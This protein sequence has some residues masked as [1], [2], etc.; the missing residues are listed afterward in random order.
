MIRANYE[1]MTRAN[2]KVVTTAGWD[3][4]TVAI[5]Y[6]FNCQT[7]RK[8]FIYASVFEQIKS[9]IIF[10]LLFFSVL[11]ELEIIWNILNILT[12]LA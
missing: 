8:K 9:K 10:Y 2:Q 1:T 11:R 6:I 3:I 12:I 7:K 5:S 4:M